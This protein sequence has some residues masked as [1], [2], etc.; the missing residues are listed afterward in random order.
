MITYDIK[1]VLGSTPMKLAK[2]SKD[3]RMIKLMTKFKRFL[4]VN[5]CNL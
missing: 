5:F 3:T 1:L 4:I 2:K